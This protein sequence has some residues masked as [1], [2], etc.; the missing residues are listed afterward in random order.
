MR[1]KIA[2]TLCFGILTLA[3]LMA[4]KLAGL[5]ESDHARFLLD[6]VQSEVG[7][8]RANTQL[9][10]QNFADQLVQ[11]AAL[12]ESL[13]T[14]ITPGLV[15][16]PFIK[17]DFLMIAL[18]E[19]EAG[20]GWRLRWSKRKS[21]V[22][23]GWTDVNESAM[24]KVLPLAAVIDNQ[25]IWH[26]S[27][28]ESGHAVYTLLVEVQ[29]PNS[30]RPTI[31]LAVLNNQAF[32][33]VIESFKA[34][35]R[36]VII[37][38]DRGHA[39]GYTQQQYVG[40]PLQ[41]HPLV[42]KLLSERKMTEVGEFKDR[43]G[44]NIIGAYQRLDGSNLFVA[45][46]QQ[47]GVFSGLLS[48]Q[49]LSLS[50]LSVA[51]FLF[52][53]AMGFMLI[54][55]TLVAY[56]YLQDLVIS[57]AQG[58]P[59]K[60]P[61][62]YSEI[63]PIL[64][65]AIQKLQQ[66]GLPAE[67]RPVVKATPVSPAPQSSNLKDFNMSA[68]QKEQIYKQIA[69]G[70]GT[71]LRDPIHVILGQ[72]QLAR[73][74][75]EGTG[76]EDHFTAIEREARRVRE[77]I[78]QLLKVSGAGAVQL[79]RADLHDVVLLALKEVKKQTDDLGVQVHKDLRP[80][81]QVTLDFK[82]M[83]TAL[84]EILKNAIDAMID[85]DRKELFV[86]AQED[87]KSIK[88]VIQDTGPGM[89]GEIVSK[90]FNPFFTTKTN[91][92]QKGLGLS[93]AKNIVESCSGKILVDS[94]GPEGTRFVIELPMTVARTEMTQLETPKSKAT[95]DVGVVKVPSPL[96]KLPQIQQSVLVDVKPLTG[97]LAA[98]LPS[99]PSIEEEVELSLL[100]LN[101]SDRPDSDLE[102]ISDDNDDEI[103]VP[104]SKTDGPSK[105]QIEEAS[106][107]GVFIRKPKLGSEE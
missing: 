16:A 15:N 23:S 56:E 44:H 64:L 50:G 60:L 24:L 69:T 62:S 104:P 38:D 100:K 58:L 54:R 83:K 74:K 80:M 73:T 53:M 71:A 79:E 42:E 32:A 93:V 2:S 35:N 29:E 34:T 84:V 19:G 3:L 27:V 39:L 101:K 63:N 47:V 76:A 46:A 21:G 20:Q 49:L 4:F 43:S 52:S 98:R 26:R 89:S 7:L 68:Q 70:L 87:G 61:E 8:V 95:P 94:T 45:V 36:E 107:T 55:P 9:V 96:D 97:S 88:L 78:D 22:S 13:R 99:T 59:L 82:K 57:L 92:G 28:S 75:S 18:L 91:F 66:S 106:V 48:A 12:E 5:S 67:S 81:G 11:A 30:S 86:V 40:A 85:S 37:L 31:A 105:H 72:A 65:Q 103:S 90:I 77:T 51:A 17:S 10:S 102:L 25:I 6:S 41:V 33:K 1:V 14:N